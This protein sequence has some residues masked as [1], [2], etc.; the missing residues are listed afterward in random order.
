[1]AAGKVSSIIRVVLPFHRYLVAVIHERYPARRHQESLSQHQ[2]FARGFFFA[3][4]T[5]HI[6]QA[7]K[8]DEHSWV[9]V[10][11]IV[12]QDFRKLPHRIASGKR[13][14]NGIEERKVK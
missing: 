1:P 9:R 2:S 11:V 6:V 14:A 3:H 7:Q 12:R 13:I 5:K 10:E 4:K 8:W